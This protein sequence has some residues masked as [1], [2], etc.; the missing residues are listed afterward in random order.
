MK[1][2]ICSIDIGSSLCHALV[3]RNR[4]SEQLEILGVG[5]TPSAGVK[6]GSIINIEAAIQAIGEAVREAELMSGLAVENALVNISGR[7]LQGDNSRGVVA[8]TNRE[9]IVTSEDV[10]RAIEG[11]RNIRLPAD[12]Q[13]VHLLSREFSVDKQSGIKDPVGM[14]GIRLEADVHIV[15]A[16]VTA[17]S[18]LNKAL[19]GCG[20]EIEGEI[21]NSLASSEAVLEASDRDMGAAVVDIGGGITDI[22]IYAEGG[23]AYSG[24]V[25]LGGIHVT[26][27]LSIGLKA[28][29]EAAEMIKKNWGV[30]VAALTD[31]TEKIELPGLSGR[32]SRQALRLQVAEIIEARSREILELVDQELIK[33][34]CKP[35]LTGGVALC[36]GS[37]LLEG[38]ESLAEE[39][40]GLSATVR[41]PF[42]LEGFSDRVSTAEFAASVGMLRYAS[43]L[44]LSSHQQRTGQPL[45]KR[46]KNWISE[47]L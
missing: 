1:D 16:G 33:S 42:G 34:G 43:Q 29:M 7:H 19:A 13:I 38:L 32:P 14:N 23:V 11:A 15:T 47:N 24:T 18:N 5:T 2:Y 20:I 45:V 12:Q 44:A 39:V 8:I 4:P 35:A 25:A 41:L 27:D 31:P 30:A 46:I 6:H 40:L 17:L 9:R 37:S 21:M 3:G 28:S 22:I 36:G 10:L 26:Q